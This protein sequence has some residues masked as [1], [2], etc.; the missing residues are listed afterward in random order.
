MILLYFTLGTFM[1]LLSAYNIYDP[2]CRGSKYFFATGILLSVLANF[3][4]LLITKSTENS[5]TIFKYAL[6][7]DV[8]LTL[9]YFAIPIA[10]FNLSM[11]FRH[12]IGVLLI[13]IGIVTLKV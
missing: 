2:T 4:W 12:W 9:S 13:L 1:Y 10:L 6:I 11:D 5:Q 3:I 8:L 7:W